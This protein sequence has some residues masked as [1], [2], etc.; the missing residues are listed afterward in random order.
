M[1]HHLGRYTHRIVIG[2]ERLLGCENDEV[3]FRWR[4]YADGNKTKVMRILV[5]AFIRRF[6]C[7][8][9]PKGFQR[10]AKQAASLLCLACP[11]APAEPLR[12]PSL[13]VLPFLKVT[14][15]DSSM[16]L[17]L[18]ATLHSC[19]TTTQINNVNDG[20]VHTR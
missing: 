18:R 12:P 6:L 7:H 15:I 4:D 5:E 19:Y 13:M 14:A 10:G 9:L 16:G 17:P 20:T 2:N 11:L 8:V 1:L 3:R